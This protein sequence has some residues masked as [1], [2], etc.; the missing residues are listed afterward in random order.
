[1]NLLVITIL[2]CVLLFPA[3]CAI[4]AGWEYGKHL[5]KCQET[6]EES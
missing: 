4:S 1:M 2:C 6:T 3:S 5:G